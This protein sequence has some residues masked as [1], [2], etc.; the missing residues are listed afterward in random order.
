[1]NTLRF[2][3]IKRGGLRSVAEQDGVCVGPREV[4][5]HTPAC[6]PLP[7]FRDL[8]PSLPAGRQVDRGE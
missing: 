7:R 4:E 6:R 2:P 3:S 8:Q 5:K 1:V